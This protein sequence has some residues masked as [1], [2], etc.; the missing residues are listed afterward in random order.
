MADLLCRK[1]LYPDEV[2]EASCTVCVTGAAG[3]VASSIVCRLLA[4]G[5]IVHATFR[6]GDHVPTLEAVKKFP[7]AQERLKWF[8]ADLLVPGSYDRAITGCK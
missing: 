1:P 3:Y 6:N 4:A 8:E 2:N 5:H 7:G